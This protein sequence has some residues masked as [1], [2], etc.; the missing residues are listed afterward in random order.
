MV[1]RVP[2]LPSED[3]LWR[4]SI[5]FPFRPPHRLDDVV[6][7]LLYAQVERRNHCPETQK[8]L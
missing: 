4:G 5:S 1:P 3:S 2:N 7:R 6:E 8:E